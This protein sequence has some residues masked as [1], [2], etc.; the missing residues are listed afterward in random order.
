M[1]RSGRGPT[2]REAQP[3]G[4]TERE[5]PGPVRYLLHG[6][7]IEYPQPVAELR[8]TE[9]EGE[10]DL[11]VGFVPRRQAA[12]TRAWERWPDGQVWPSCSSAVINGATWLRFHGFADVEV[13]SSRLGVRARC[14]HLVARRLLHE[15]VVPMLAVDRGAFSVHG[16]AFGDERRG[17]LV[18]GPSRAGKSTLTALAASVGAVVAG[19][20]CI[21]LAVLAGGVT[22]HRSVPS[23]RIGTTVADELGIA[24][25]Q[26]TGDRLTVRVEAC[27]GRLRPTLPI[28]RLFVLGDP[29]PGEGFRLE[30][31]TVGEVLPDLA[32]QTRAGLSPW[33]APD[34]LDRAASLLGLLELGRLR[35]PRGVRQLRAA[36]VHGLP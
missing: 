32:R 1:T 28:D 27:G 30:R 8:G 21:T 34:F 35:C 23:L 24:G 25:S 14:A 4:P 6:L 7:S 9:A 5:R 17:A 16:C 29:H 18:L 26:A 3:S 20:D 15:R 10:A 31:A 2:E 12:P 33:S 19:D 36:L 11:R 22:A 13:T